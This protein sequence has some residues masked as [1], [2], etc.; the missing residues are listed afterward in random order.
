MSS[1]A[2]TPYKTPVP[3]IN[4]AARWREQRLAGNRGPWPGDTRQIPHCRAPSSNLLA[5]EAT[6]TE[7]KHKGEAMSPYC[8]RLGA[9]ALALVCGVS[10]V[11]AAPFG[12]F[13]PRSMAMGWTGVSS[14]TGGNAAYF[15]PAFVRTLR[16]KFRVREKVRFDAFDCRCGGTPP[17]AV[18]RHPRRVTT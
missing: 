1:P 15:N 17:F 13:D 11:Q 10:A 12:V 7:R 5:A 6:G 18:Q 2:N 9:V 16:D 8:A 14:G 4:N 3:P